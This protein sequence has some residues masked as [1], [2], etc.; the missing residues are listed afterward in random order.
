LLRWSEKM[1]VAGAVMNEEDNIYGAVITWPLTEGVKSSALQMNRWRISTEGAS[2]TSSKE[3]IKWSSRKSIPTAVVRVNADGEPYSL[4]QREDGIWMYIPP[5]GDR[6]QSLPD[7]ASEHV[8]PVDIV[9]VNDVY[10]L[11]LYYDG[12]TGLK[13]TPIAIIKKN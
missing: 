11:L 6:P 4:L 5:G 13:Y 7:E 1:L 12:K 8:G 2:K 3:I 9:F 10:P